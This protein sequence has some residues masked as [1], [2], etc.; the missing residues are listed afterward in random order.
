MA[1][2]DKEDFTTISIRRTEYKKLDD[3]KEYNSEP[4]WLVIKR[5]LEEKK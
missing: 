4:L 2:K 1:R 5:L 3:Y